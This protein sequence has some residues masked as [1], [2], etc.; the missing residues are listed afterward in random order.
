MQVEA[1]NVL[2]KGVSNSKIIEPGS[3]LWFNNG[4]LL[5]Y[6]IPQAILGPSAEHTVL[7]KVTL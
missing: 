5:S 1:V 7:Q 4:L 6:L 3:T 2:D